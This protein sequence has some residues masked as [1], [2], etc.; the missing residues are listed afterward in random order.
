MAFPHDKAPRL[1]DDVEAQAAGHSTVEHTDHAPM[2]LSSTEGHHDLDEKNLGEYE[3]LDRYITNGGH[4]RQESVVDEDEHIPAWKFWKSSTA[5]RD[6]APVSN[7]PPPD[8]LE[9]DIRRGITSH[10]VEHRRKRFG[11]NELTA[12]KVNQFAK[13]MSF[14]QGP[15]LYG[16]YNGGL[17][18]C[19]SNIC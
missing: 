12:E 9:T 7:K 19:A 13:F 17:P 4:A 6:A 18:S 8:W 14:F 16:K 3:R 15:I 1:S 10:D 5:L 2:D 11:Y